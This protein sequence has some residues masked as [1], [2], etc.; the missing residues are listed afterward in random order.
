MGFLGWGLIKLFPKLTH[1]SAFSIPQTRE[2]AG[3]RRIQA[4]ISK[5]ALRTRQRKQPSKKF[6]G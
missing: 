2:P 5:F 6:D 4:G 3:R 1:K